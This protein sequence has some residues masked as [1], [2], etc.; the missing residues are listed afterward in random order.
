MLINFSCD[1]SHKVGEKIDTGVEGTS[2]SN[3]YVL[4]EGTVAKQGRL[5]NT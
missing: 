4:A 1:C 2:F 5:W 3:D